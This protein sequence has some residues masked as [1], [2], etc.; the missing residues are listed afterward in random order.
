MK[1]HK[2]FIILV[3]LLVFLC[4]FGTIQRSEAADVVALQPS[5]SIVKFNTTSR[6]DIHEYNSGV[7]HNHFNQVVEKLKKENRLIK[8]VT[9]ITNVRG[10]V[11]MEHKIYFS[12]NDKVKD[13]PTHK[14]FFISS[15]PDDCEKY[16]INLCFEY[17]YV[18][19]LHF[20]VT[21]NGL[22]MFVFETNI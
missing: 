5:V 7:F 16:F 4:G 2:R 1:A 13:K 15:S 21:Q 12:N 17:E 10:K 6:Y 20:G 9:F 19:L 11:T 8:V 14:I 3:L 22:R 18:N